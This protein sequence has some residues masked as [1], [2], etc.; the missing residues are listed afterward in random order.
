MPSKKKKIEVRSH[1]KNYLAELFDV[2]PVYVAL[3]IREKR[4]NK[5]ITDAYNTMAE[6]EDKARKDV[7]SSVKKMNAVKKLA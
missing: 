5:A 3:V 1:I 4:H 2:S 7:K 6:Q